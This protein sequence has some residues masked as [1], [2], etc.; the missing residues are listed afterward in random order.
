MGVVRGWIVAGAAPLLMLAAA[1][2]GTRI[3]GIGCNSDADCKAGR[4]L[5]KVCV[6]QT[7]CE[8]ACPAHQDCLEATCVDAFEA[9]RIVS[10]IDQSRV[11]D[12]FVVAAQIVPRSGS[13][14]EPP[15]TLDAQL[16]RATGETTNATLA[17]DPETKSHRAQVQVGRGGVYALRVVL[18]GSPLAA[19][20]SVQ[21]DLCSSACPADQ[22]CFA[23]QCAT[24][25]ELVTIE[26]PLANG[27]TDAPLN[28]VARLHRKA[29]AL[30]PLPGVL[31]YSRGR[32]TFTAERSR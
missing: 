16:T 8:P 7:E 26:E 31:T 15:A 10:P 4:C 11:S 13:A 21:V 6:R 22:E 19:Q 12:G 3:P 18:P 25:F 14:R 23:D 32:T 28:V 20:S 9:I 29:G 1:G 30:R 2:C 27:W 24:A 5:D 17:W